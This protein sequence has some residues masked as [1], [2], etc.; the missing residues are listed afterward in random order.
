MKIK[1]LGFTHTLD[2]ELI[3]KKHNEN[4]SFKMKK[5]IKGNRSG[6]KKNKSM[7]LMRQH[8]GA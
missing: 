7:G 6:N 8:Y 1:I 3:F 5:K 2:E 4:L